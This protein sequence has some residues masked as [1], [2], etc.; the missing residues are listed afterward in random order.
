LRLRGNWPNIPG[1][2]IKLGLQFWTVR[3]AMQTDFAGTIREVARMGYDGVEGG[4]TGPLSVEDYNK[5]MG[6]LG[7]VTAGVHTGGKVLDTK[8]DEMMAFFRSIGAKYVGISAFHEDPDSWKRL[9]GNLNRYGTLASRH[10]L[11]FQY[12]NHA[13]EFRKFGDKNGMDLLVENSDPKTVFFQVDVGWCRHAVEDPVYWLDRLKGRIVTVHLKDC[14]PP[15]NPKWTEVGNG[16]L[17]VA[18]VVKAANDVGAEWFFVEQDT[19]ERPSIEAA[20]ISFQNAS[21]V[22]KG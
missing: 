2:M 8:G 1:T 5:L 10:G 13:S 22:I 6:E 19:W 16:G 7:I 9:A 11:T 14:T 20:R 18:A 12:H 3:D 15:P 4:S 17:D 21:K